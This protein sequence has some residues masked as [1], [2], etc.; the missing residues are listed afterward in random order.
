MAEG[1]L[2]EL[3]VDASQAA[4]Q[5]VNVF[6]FVQKAAGSGFMGQALIDDWQA[7]PQA[8]WLAFCNASYTIN[9]YRAVD[10]HPGTSARVEESMSSGNTGG[11]GSLTLPNQ[12]G[13]LISW[14]TA[15][16]G[17][18][19][20]GRT[21]TPTPGGTLT[22]AN[23]VATAGITAITAFRDAYLTR[24]GPSGVS[25]YFQAAVISRYLNGAERTVPVGTLITT[26]IV[27]SFLATQRRRR[28]GV[29][30]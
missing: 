7:G 11:A 20:R 29:G 12:V 15:Q 22:S 17:R 6:G 5:V 1:D 4:N 13:G 19:Y 10:V 8:S 21:Y 16:A 28:L 14:R 25:T 26:G 23:A 24:F 2:Y 9:T 30:S 18:S 3:V 27:R